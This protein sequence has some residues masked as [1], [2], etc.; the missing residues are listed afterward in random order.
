MPPAKFSSEKIVKTKTNSEFLHMVREIIVSCG[1]LPL[2]VLVEGSRRA[3]N[4]VETFSVWEN[5]VSDERN[6]E[7][8]SGFRGC[9]LFALFDTIVR[10]HNK[11]KGLDLHLSNLYNISY[12][13]DL[14]QQR[15]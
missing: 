6:A 13:F 9:F 10:L 14:I 11:L 15:N 3:S 2:Q 1:H 5:F 7:W 4:Y 8:K 12:T